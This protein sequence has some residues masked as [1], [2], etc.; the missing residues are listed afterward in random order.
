MATTERRH[1]SRDTHRA[2]RQ[3]QRTA[4]ANAAARGI[5]MPT[6]DPRAQRLINASESAFSGSVEP[7]PD[8]EMMTRPVVPVSRADIGQFE[9]R[10][11]EVVCTTMGVPYGLLRGVGSARIKGETDQ[12]MH[13]FRSSV[14]H[15]RADVQLFYQWVHEELHRWK[16]NEFLAVTLLTAQKTEIDDQS[17]AEQ[18]R[19]REIRANI[20]VISQ[21]PSRV[22]VSFPENPLPKT[23][24]L[25]MLAAAGAAGAIT[26]EEQTNILRGQLGLANIDSDHVLL[27]R[28]D[29]Y[30]AP[31]ANLQTHKPGTGNAIGVGIIGPDGSSESTSAP[32][33]A[34]AAASASAAKPAS[35]P[36]P[37]SAPTPPAQAQSRANA[38]NKR[39]KE[40]AAAPKKSSS[41]VRLEPARTRNAAKRS[42][43]A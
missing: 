9:E 23:V 29:A 32:A 25:E 26:L 6:L 34:S 13:V 21:M 1:Y 24:S 10:Y 35:A 15:D 38:D 5:V 2:I 30:S 16:D 33:P 11:A 12:M 43:N 37:K 40:G 42:R 41:F 8:G 20:D 28:V 31:T 4:E 36:K 27:Q 22:T 19:L 3:E 17:P 7:L 18:Q 14:E 39:K